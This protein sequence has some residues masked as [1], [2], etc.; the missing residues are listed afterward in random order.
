M[1]GHHGLDS[2]SLALD[3]LAESFGGEREAAIRERLDKAA[4][5]IERQVLAIVQLFG[6]ID[7]FRGQNGLQRREVKRLGVGNDSVA[8]EDDRSQ[9]KPS[10]YP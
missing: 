8:V 10:S 9:H 6:E 5:I 7:S 4:A 1:S 2:S 3:Q